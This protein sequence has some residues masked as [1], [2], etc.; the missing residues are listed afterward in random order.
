[1]ESGRL[2]ESSVMTNDD[3][4]LRLRNLILHT[5][6]ADRTQRLQRSALSRVPRASCST[7]RH[8]KPNSGTSMSTARHCDGCPLENLPDVLIVSILEKISEKNCAKAIAKCAL[9]CKR[10]A[11]LV[12]QV[13]A[14]TFTGKI[15]HPCYSSQAQEDKLFV[16]V[17]TRTVLKTKCLRSLK[18]TQS[19][20][21]FA[22]EV[23]DR[24]LS[25]VGPW[26]EELSLEVDTS[27]GEIA[28]FSLEVLLRRCQSL[29]KLYLSIQ[30]LYIQGISI[31]EDV[32][33]LALVSNHI[34]EDKWQ[35]Y[36]SSESLISLRGSAM[37]KSLRHLEVWGMLSGF[38][39]LGGSQLVAEPLT[40][41]DLLFSL[42]PDLETLVIGLQDGTVENA[43]ME[44]TSLP[45]L[46][47]LT[48][49]A[50]T[51]T[52]QGASFSFIDALIVDAPWLSKVDVNG[53]C[54]LAIKGKPNVEELKVAA[55]SH[56][57]SRLPSPNFDGGP[58]IELGEEV[59]IHSLVLFRTTG[60]W[61][62][63]HDLPYGW[64]WCR[65]KSLLNE[66]LP[67]GLES[68]VLKDLPICANTPARL[69]VPCNRVIDTLLADTNFAGASFAESTLNFAS[70]SASDLAACSCFQHLNHLEIHGFSLISFVMRPDLMSEGG[71]RGS[72]SGVRSD[73][74]AGLL[75]APKLR[76]VVLQ[77]E[78]EAMRW[79]TPRI[80]PLLNS[81]LA[82]C[83]KLEELTVRV[84][85]FRPFRGVDETYSALDKGVRELAK[86]CGE[87]VL[88]L[89][90]DYMMKNGQI[91]YDDEDEDRWHDEDFYESVDYDGIMPESGG[92]TD[93]DDYEGADEYQVADEGEGSQVIEDGNEDNDDDD[94]DDGDE[95][96]LTPG[97]SAGMIDIDGASADDHTGILEL[98]LTEQFSDY[99]ATGWSRPLFD[100]H[101]CVSSRSLATTFIDSQDDMYENYSIGDSEV[102][103]GYRG[104]S[105]ALSCL[106]RGSRHG[107]L[108]FR[109]E[110]VQSNRYVP[111]E[112]ERDL[113]EDSGYEVAEDSDAV[114]DL[115]VPQRSIDAAI[116]GRD[117]G[118]LRRNCDGELERGQVCEG[119]NTRRKREGRQG[120]IA[121]EDEGY[122]EDDS[123]GFE[124]EI[125]RDRTVDGG[126][127]GTA[128][129][130]FGPYN[131][132]AIFQDENQ[133]AFDCLEDSL[134]DED[135]GH[136]PYDDDD[137]DDDFY[138]PDMSFSRDS[139]FFSGYD[140]SA[141]SD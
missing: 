87:N 122:S 64:T 85:R 126:Q 100:G 44:V 137:V 78:G 8:L 105:D 102:L 37:C 129:V 65:L 23:L 49:S 92:T 80:W 22:S 135:Y 51:V 71:T 11:Q 59:K 97:H 104:S 56:C 74:R 110:D 28:I 18:V 57:N 16:E 121:E 98:D 72:D 133:A 9:V 55:I 134:E 114:D 141:E 68:L 131:V 34:H 103:L 48:V 1:M 111:T 54:S 140:E 109:E 53:V 41:F 36:A 40:C 128:A 99:T 76:T 32:T 3:V 73:G 116:S 77:I 39:G 90:V 2:G 106:E 30:D 91:Y 113:V 119:S 63:Q 88:K 12:W 79:V 118:S 26:L 83:P 29:R 138:S 115:V 5:D 62:S 124:E 60:N 130:E 21:I 132:D 70:L 67:A 35:E 52:P 136:G 66:K 112:D 89:S 6:V 125:H 127:P 42:F 101:R 93:V 7:P 24:I 82:G 27:A 31:S 14:L 20:G 120:L 86:K 47:E 108:A 123:S 69:S 38:S 15:R 96:N 4:E 75:H 46:Q 17:V 43:S 139:E 19:P 81:F 61:L 10:F 94:D 107:L 45:K 50:A 95:G 33:R 84:D 13:P 117:G 25:H 58:D